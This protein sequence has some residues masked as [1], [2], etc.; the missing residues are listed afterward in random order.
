[1]TIDEIHQILVILA[2]HLNVDEGTIKLSLA[3]LS[4]ISSYVKAFPLDSYLPQSRTQS[5]LRKILPHFFI[6]LV[7]RPKPPHC[8][9]YI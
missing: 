6:R 4:N 2:K 3:K 9:P 5:P 7:V 8:N 1:M